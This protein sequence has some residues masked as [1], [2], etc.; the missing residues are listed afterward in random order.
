[1][2]GWWLVVASVVAWMGAA[3]AAP[4]SPVGSEFQV[5][6][7]TSFNS[8][9][10]VAPAPSGDALVVWMDNAA[11]GSSGGI[12]A[13]RASSTGSVLGTEFLLNT[14]TTGSQDRSHVASVPGGGFVVTWQS[15]AQDGS[16]LA[17]VARRFASDGAALGS[18]IAVNAY[19]TGAQQRPDVAVDGAGGFVVVWDSAAEDGDQ[20]GVFGQRFTSAGVPAGSE[21]RVNGYTTSY[22][23]QPAVAATASGGFVVVWDSFGQDGDGAGVFARR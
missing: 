15:Y 3:N 14:T 19:T 10:H 17:V 5:N 18:E 4:L 22:Q 1:M 12:L 20:T 11:D 7:S 2:R 21:F 8:Y 23:Y 6:T 16:S 13:R 9:P